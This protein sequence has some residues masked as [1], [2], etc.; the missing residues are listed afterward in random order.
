MSQVDMSCITKIVLQLTKCLI[1]KSKTRKKWKHSWLNSYRH[2]MKRWLTCIKLLLLFKF[3]LETF[4][5]LHQR[6]SAAKEIQ[7]KLTNHVNTI[8]RINS[9]VNIKKQERPK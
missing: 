1:P 5:F 3:A 9:D 8:T 4:V 6:T 2:H 7:Y